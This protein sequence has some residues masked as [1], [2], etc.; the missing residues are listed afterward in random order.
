MSVTKRCKESLLDKFLFLALPSH[1]RE[2]LLA[3]LAR[4][5]E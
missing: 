4:V 1:V 3:V 2:C 5:R